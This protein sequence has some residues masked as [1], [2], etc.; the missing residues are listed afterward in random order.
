MELPIRSG[1]NSAELGGSPVPNIV[2]ISDK[3]VEN[4]GYICCLVV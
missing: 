4:V 1:K 2:V 3:V